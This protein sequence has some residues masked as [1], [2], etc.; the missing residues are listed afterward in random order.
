MKSNRNFRI[1]H[2]KILATENNLMSF[3]H[4]GFWQPMDTLY[5]KNMLNDLWDNGKAPWKKW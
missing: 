3:K 4:Y 1:R 2:L 5:E